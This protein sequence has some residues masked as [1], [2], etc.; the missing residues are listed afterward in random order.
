MLPVEGYAMT[1]EPMLTVKQIAE[2][3]QVHPETVRGWLRARRMRGMLLADHM[4]WRVPESEVRR[5][6][7]E[8]L[9]SQSTSE[10]G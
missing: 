5:F 7:A 10:E 6:V 8:G 9:A 3:L 1:E 4:G 2:S